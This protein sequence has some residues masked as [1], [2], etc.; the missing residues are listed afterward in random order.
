MLNQQSEPT[1][2]GLE[3][4]ESSKHDIILL[5]KSKKILDSYFGRVTT[6]MTIFMGTVKTSM[7][8]RGTI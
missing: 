4:I 8:N 1:T 3:V 5:N 2:S 6:F 7:K